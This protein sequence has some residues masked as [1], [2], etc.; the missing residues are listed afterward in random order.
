MIQS[1]EF[2]VGDTGATLGGDQYCILDL[3][4]TG[5]E[6][7]DGK[8][9]AVI[10]SYQGRSRFI[11]VDEEG[12]VSENGSN[13]F[14]LL[15]PDRVLGQRGGLEVDSVVWDVLPWANFITQDL[16]GDVWAFEAM[17]EARMFGFSFGR[18]FAEEGATVNIGNDVAD[19]I[20]D[21]WRKWFARRP[22]EFDGKFY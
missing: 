1:W 20:G 8:I 13:E 15:T 14:D 21:I 11:W 18:W 19:P 5:I 3:N 4:G 16:Y 7:P 22:K 12:R 2:E 17:P 9:A 6:C 10:T